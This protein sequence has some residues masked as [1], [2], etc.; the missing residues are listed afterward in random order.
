MPFDVI[1]YY[2]FA[3]GFNLFNGR[4]RPAPL[5]LR[6]VTIK[7]KTTPDL[8]Q[9]RFLKWRGRRRERRRRRRRRREQRSMFET[10]L[11]INK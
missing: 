11:L 4:Q 7:S 5:E 2:H 6:N 9:F 10:G 3:V 8:L 1:T